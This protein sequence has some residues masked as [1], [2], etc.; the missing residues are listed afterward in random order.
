MTGVTCPLCGGSGRL[1]ECLQSCDGSHREDLTWT[2]YCAG[3]LRPSDT[4]LLHKHFYGWSERNG[5]ETFTHE[6]ERGNEPHEHVLRDGGVEVKRTMWL[7]L[8]P[9]A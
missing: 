4:G 9:P 5:T 3:D 1:N 6:H 2:C 8:D 7:S